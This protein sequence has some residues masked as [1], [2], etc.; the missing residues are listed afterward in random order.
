MGYSTE[1]DTGRQVHIDRLQRLQCERR[2]KARR[3]HRRDA[4]Q[5]CPEHRCGTS[6]VGRLQYLRLG[7]TFT[8]AE[9]HAL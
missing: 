4:P 8:V 3:S 1:R 7:P 2:Q 9:M 5:L 6:S